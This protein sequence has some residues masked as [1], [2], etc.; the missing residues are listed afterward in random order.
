[1]GADVPQNDFDLLDTTR[2]RAWWTKHEAYQAA[3]ALVSY[4][5]G[6]GDPRLSVARLDEIGLYDEAA[7]LAKASPRTQSLLEQ[8][9]EQMRSH[10]ATARLSPSDL[11]REMG[12]DCAGV[13]KDLAIRLNGY[14]KQSE[15]ERV[16]GYGVLELQYL[17]TNCVVNGEPQFQIAEY[18]VAT[19]L[20]GSRYAAVNIV[21]K[22]SGTSLDPY[23][24]R[25]LEEWLKSRKEN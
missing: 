12:R 1:M 16:D 11:S 6:S 9:R 5:Q 14:R 15:Q 20:L 17:E 25:P 7:R 18:G 21:N 3:V 2:L 4:A 8:L 22:A 23:E 13:Q 10:A 19:R 24:S